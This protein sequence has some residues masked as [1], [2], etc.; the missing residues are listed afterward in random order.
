MY[1]FFEILGDFYS[2]ILFLLNR[3]QFE[4]AG[5]DVS[6]GHIL[7]SFIS[8]SMIVSIFWKGAKG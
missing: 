7:L 5:V 8:V 1:H 2:D 4:F 6:I 3:S